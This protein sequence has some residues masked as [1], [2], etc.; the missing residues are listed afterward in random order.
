[1]NPFTFNTQ[2]IEFWLENFTSSPLSFKI[3]CALLSLIFLSF[4]LFVLIKT[5]IIKLALLYPLTEFFSVRFYGF[6]KALR[7]WKKIEKKLKTKKIN[8][9]GHL[10]L[11]ADQILDF[12]LK[13]LVPVYQAKN[14]EERLRTTGLK[15]FSNPKLLWQAHIFCQDQIRA[16]RKKI[17]NQEEA[18]R[19]LKIYEQALRDLEIIS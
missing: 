5:K 6:R 19:I 16:E 4:I 2:S 7:Q 15:T 10:V 8:N 18:L 12:L 17:L 14:F 11:K 1:M 3:I 13:N 9:Y